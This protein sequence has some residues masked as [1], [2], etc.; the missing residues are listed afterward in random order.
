MTSRG[1]GPKPSENTLKL[2]EW[3]TKLPGEA[4]DKATYQAYRKASND[5][6]TSAAIFNIEKRKAALARGFAVKTRAKRAPAPPPAEGPG[7]P[8]PAAGRAIK[9]LA[10]IPLEKYKALDPKLLKEF[11]LDV[12]WAVRGKPDAVQVL[13][14]SDPPAFEIREP[15]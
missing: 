9:I 15:A 14:L 6:K 4:F 8:M 2:R 10:T 13:T 5:V 7:L 1:K 12:I 11:A 3:L